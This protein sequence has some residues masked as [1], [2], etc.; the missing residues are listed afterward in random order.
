MTMRWSFGWQAVVVTF[1]YMGSLITPVTSQPQTNLLLRSCSL[2]NTTNTRSFFNNLNQTFTEVRRQL[3]TDDTFFATGEQARSSEPV[4][5]MAQC[6]R[7]MTTADCLAC[8]DY[9]TLAIR[10]CAA[11][12][13]ARAVLDGCFLRYETTDFYDEATQPGNVG[14]CG[15]RTATRPTRF[16]TAV[17]GLLSNLTIATPRIKDLFA[18]SSSNIS[19]SNRSVYAIAQCVPTLAHNGCKD[20][21][22]VAYSNIRNCLPSIVDAR[23]LDTGCFMRYSNTPFFTNNETTIITPFLREG[24]SKKGAIIGG[25]VGGV[26]LLSTIVLV[27]ILMWYCRSKR[28]TT[29]RGNSHGPNDQLQDPVKYSYSDLRKATKNFCDDHK[30]GEGGFGGVYKGTINNGNV[31]AVK[32]LLVSSAKADFEREVRVIS[33]VHHRNLIRLLGCCSEGPELLLVLEY[34]ENGSLVKFLYG[35]RK[36]TLTWKQRCNIIFGI[37][38]GLAYLHE[39]YHVT[40]IHRDIN[41]SNILLDDD[42]QPKIADFGLAKLLPEDQTHISTRFAGTLGYTAPEYAIHGQLSEKADTYSFGI[43]VLEIISG[44]RCTDVLDMSP[45]DQYLLE[46]ALNVYENHMPLQLI[47]ETL[48]PNEYTE[49]EVKKMIEIALTCT[50]SPAERPTMSEV[51][52]LLNDRSREQKPPSRLQFDVPNIN[53]QVDQDIASSTSNADV[54]LTELTGR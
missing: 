1:L 12:D 6:R 28:K 52:V 47:D 11:A 31:V 45:P 29:P 27:A 21:L 16:Q 10:A 51:L 3:S 54:S 20:C 14:L 35:E 48:D 8:Y 2:L 18:A 43:V 25:V 24:S 15:N 37:A 46:H 9:A 5:V 41:P 13:G 39:Q 4:Y 33:N 38:K 36:G 26:G 32:K 50:Q 53:I 7:Y 23:A 44:K 19:G 34:M 22:R 42:F 49:Q 17:D 30:L 40:I